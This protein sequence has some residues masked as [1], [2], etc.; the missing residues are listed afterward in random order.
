MSENYAILDQQLNEDV[1]EVL[2]RLQLQFI[3]RQRK[4]CLN[5]LDVSAPGLAN[6]LKTAGF[7]EIG[8]WP[9]LTCTEDTYV[10]EL[11][12]PGLAFE[13]ISSE[14]PLEAVREGWNANARGYDMNADLATDEQVNEFRNHPGNWRGFTARLY[15][16]VVGAGMFEVIRNGVTELVGITTLEPYRRR[17]IASA[18]T[19]HAT[20]IAFSMGVDVT[21]LIPANNEAHRIYTR[22]GYQHHATQMSY[23]LSIAQ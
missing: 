21:F 19:A 6:H 18:L 10:A 14:S 17:G 3:E 4:P 15:G 1:D 9:L 16:E 11:Q 2:A 8:K 13:M 12:V 23:R 20:Q 5:F 22:V 7:E